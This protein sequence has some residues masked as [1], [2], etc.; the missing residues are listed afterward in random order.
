M[1]WD[2]LYKRAE[3][4]GCGDDELRAKDEARWQVCEIARRMGID[5]EAEEIPE[6]AIEDFCNKHKIEFDIR[7]DI[8]E[9]YPLKWNDLDDNVKSILEWIENPFTGKEEIINIKAG[10]D[11][12]RDYR[13]DL[14]FGYKNAYPFDTGEIKIPVTEEIYDTILDYISTDD[15]LSVVIDEASQS[16]YFGLKSVMKDFQLNNNDKIPDNE[17]DLEI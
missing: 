5:L 2:E 10:E 9:F 13:K 1:N 15:N 6:D 11:F 14:T 8:L 4:K 7:G 17:I 12:Y 3:G 16:V